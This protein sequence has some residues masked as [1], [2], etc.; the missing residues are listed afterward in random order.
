MMTL[1][2]VFL[3]WFPLAVTISNINGDK[4]VKNT[5]KSLLFVIFTLP[6]I[7]LA[8]LDRHLIR[9][10]VGNWLMYLISWLHR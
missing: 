8:F 5:W 1:L 3:L 10:T 2:F 4:R 6:C 9:G 7:W